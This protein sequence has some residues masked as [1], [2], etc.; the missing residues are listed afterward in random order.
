MSDLIFQ[1]KQQRYRHLAAL[2]RFTEGDTSQ[3]VNL[4]QLCQKEGISFD[5]AAY[6]YL[7]NEGLITLYGAGYACFLSHD[8]VKAIEEAWEQPN[9][10]STY[11]PALNDM[12]PENGS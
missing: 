3:W 1:R 7:V 10:P 5:E 2:Y 9:R 4:K 8:G 6:E 11:F 12:K